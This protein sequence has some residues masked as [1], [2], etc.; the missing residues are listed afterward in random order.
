MAARAIRSVSSCHGRSR[1]RKNVRSA[2]AIWSRRA[3]AS[4]VQIRHVAM[5]VQRK[6]MSS[7]V[8]NKNAIS[9]CGFQ[10]CG[11]G[12]FVWQHMV[13]ISVNESR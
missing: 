2:E 11:D 1:W 9:I 6:K 4:S 3:T 12:L 10:R 7:V 5:S 8:I 13:K